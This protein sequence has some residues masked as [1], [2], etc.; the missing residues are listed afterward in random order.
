M[1]K[2]P[3]Y[4][5]LGWNGNS[6][7]TQKKII[8]ILSFKNNGMPVWG[9]TLL[10]KH[11]E[12]KIYRFI[13]EYSKKTSMLLR[14][15]KQIYTVRTNKR[16]PRTKKPILKSIKSNMIIFDRLTPLNEYLKGVYEYYVPQSDI[17]DAFV[18]NNGRWY[19]FSDV[20]AR[21]PNRKTPRT[22]RKQIENQPV[23]SREFYNP[24]NQ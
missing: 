4:I 2:K 20:D 3:Y 11:E 21:N 15:D 16:D 17:F 12:G 6:P 23:R 13:F 10:K 9:A 14:Y 8:E 1:N 18:L 22:L 24:K 5:L 7:F 19:F